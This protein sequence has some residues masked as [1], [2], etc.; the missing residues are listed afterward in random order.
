[1]LIG[2]TIATGTVLGFAGGWDTA[3]SVT[4]ERDGREASK[5]TLSIT[6]GGL[7]IE[8]YPDADLGLRLHAR[9]GYA[10]QNREWCN[11]DFRGCHEDGGGVGITPVSLGSAWPTAFAAWQP[12]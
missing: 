12:A 5:A 3:P 7:F 9:L 10:S 6:H 1:V 8:G 2:A 4:H 11:V